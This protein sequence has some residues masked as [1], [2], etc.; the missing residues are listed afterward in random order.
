MYKPS[1]NPA[2]VELTK[3]HRERSYR[4]GDLPYIRV[5]G[6]KRCYWCGD[7]LKTKHHAQRYCKDENC[8]RSAFAW[9]NPQKENG[10]WF[11]LQKQDWKCAIC[12]FDWKQYVK[13]HVIG[14]SYGTHSKTDFVEFNEYLVIRLKQKIEQKYKPEVDHI[15][16]I[17]K[18]G[19]ALGLDNHQI[20]C[21]TDHKAKSKIDNSGPRKKKCTD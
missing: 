7:P 8:S 4:I 2:V 21:F 6:E 5:D 9:G 15:I 12:Q 1:I 19:Q 3:S 20:L 13:D 16:P 11:L 17:Y 10:M 18:G 14:K